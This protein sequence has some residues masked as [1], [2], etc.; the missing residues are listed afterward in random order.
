MGNN[1]SEEDK[2]KVRL[3]AKGIM[4]NFMK[5]LNE[6]DNPSLE[7]GS[8]RNKDVRDFFD[9]KYQGDEFRDMFLKNAKNTEDN[10]IVAERKKW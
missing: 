8:Q 2:E 4:E 5:A 7:F 1:L 3:K 6:V 9:N 10:Q